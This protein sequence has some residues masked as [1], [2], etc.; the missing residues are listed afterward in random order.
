M[1]IDTASLGLPLRW[2]LTFLGF[3]IGGALA[4]A[5]VRSANTPLSSA[6]GGLI[7]GAALGLAQWLVLRTQ[8]PLGPGWIAATALGLAVGLPASL[9]A[10]GDGLDTGSIVARALLVGLAVGA[11]QWVVLRTISPWAWVWVIGVAA[12]WAIGWLVTRAA[13]VD[14][15][16]HWTVFGSTGALVF[17]ALTAAMLAALLRVPR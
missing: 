5:V 3:P 8:L 2:L 10:V 7:T 13:G 14:L 4:Y 9:L 11:A 15:S 6:V 17:A 1:S 16:F 12:A